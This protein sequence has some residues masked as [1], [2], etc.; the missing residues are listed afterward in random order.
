MKTTMTTQKTI[1]INKIK[2]TA[3]AIRRAPQSE[4]NGGHN[5]AA[6]KAGEIHWMDYDGEVKIFNAGSVQRE[7]GFGTIVAFL[8]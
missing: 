1:T 6:T 4:S 5:I 3:A 7:Q 2:L 8:A